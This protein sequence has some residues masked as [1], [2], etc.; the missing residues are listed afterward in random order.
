ML[1]FATRRV[2]AIG[3]AMVEMAPVGDGLYRRGFAGDTFNTGWH[4]AQLLGDAACVGF[5]TRVGCDG[6]SDA[7][8]AEIAADG[9]DVSGIARDPERGMGLYLIKL[10]G[11]ERSF[12]YWRQCSAA[13]RLAD[14]PTSLAATVQ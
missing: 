14:D 10:D 9:L 1:T 7:F 4:M 8:V 3:E 5:V 6:L 12:H 13:R 2:V 11:V